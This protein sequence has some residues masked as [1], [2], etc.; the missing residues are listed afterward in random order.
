MYL[1]VKLCIYVSSY[2][3]FYLLVIFVI[4]CFRFMFINRT[5]KPINKSYSRD[6]FLQKIMQTVQIGCLLGAWCFL[7]LVSILYHKEHIQARNY[8]NNIIFPLVA[9]I[10]DC[11][12]SI[13]LNNFILYN[14][15]ATLSLNSFH[16]MWFPIQPRVNKARFVT[17]VPRTSSAGA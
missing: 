5:H 7:G 2:K 11:C 3:A 12:V 8:W 9:G 4:S 10:S 14:K 15:S 17:L 16:D 13:I 6:S 1:V